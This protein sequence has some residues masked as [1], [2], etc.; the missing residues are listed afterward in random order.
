MTRYYILVTWVPRVNPRIDWYGGVVLLLQERSK[1]PRLMV[2]T[3]KAETS[4]LRSHIDYRVE[5]LDVPNSD[6]AAA[7]RVNSH[8]A[9]AIYLYL[10]LGRSGPNLEPGTMRVHVTNGPQNGLNIGRKV[11]PRPESWRRWVLGSVHACFQAVHAANTYRPRF[12][13]RIR[14]SYVYIFV[15]MSRLMWAVMISIFISIS[16]SIY[17]S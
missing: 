10:Y 4:N 7:N 12:Q 14:P 6:A 1:Y 16:M 13:V 3:P 5:E 9:G 11:G 17:S 15:L 8:P 2:R